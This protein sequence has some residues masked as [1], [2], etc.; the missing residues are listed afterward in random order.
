MEFCEDFE[1]LLSSSKQWA[2]ITGL[3]IT[4]SLSLRFQKIGVLQV[5][6]SDE[7]VC[8]WNGKPSSSTSLTPSTYCNYFPSNTITR[9]HIP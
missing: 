3:T 8:N 5:A 1:S 2:V 9:T 4:D 6:V 7:G